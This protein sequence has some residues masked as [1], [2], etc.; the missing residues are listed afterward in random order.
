M[1]T[2]PSPTRTRPAG[3]RIVSSGY[4]GNKKDELA[5]PTLLD[6]CASDCRSFERSHALSEMGQ[7]RYDRYSNESIK[8][9]T[10]IYSN[11]R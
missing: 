8:Q 6:M 3:K 1:P 5:Q 10:L 11:T 4:H 9:A 2:S 7:E